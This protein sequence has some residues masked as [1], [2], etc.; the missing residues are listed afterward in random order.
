MRTKERKKESER[1]RKTKCDI[2][3]KTKQR[4]AKHVVPKDEGRPPTPKKNK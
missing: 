1:K 3:I 4:A 2:E